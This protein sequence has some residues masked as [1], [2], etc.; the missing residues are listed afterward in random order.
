MPA[1]VDLEE[2][3]AVAAVADDIVPGVASGPPV[4]WAATA[5]SRARIEAVAAGRARR[6]AEA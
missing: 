6:S 5:A 2:A 1:V 3:V 4:S